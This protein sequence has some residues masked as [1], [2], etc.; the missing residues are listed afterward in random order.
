M[1]NTESGTRK[2]YTKDFK[3][4]AV[5]MLE[6]GQKTGEQIEE[7]LGIGSGQVYKWR[8]ELAAHGQQAFPGNGNPRDEELARLR[9][10]NANLREERDILRKAVAIFSKPSR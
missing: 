5:Q 4:R 6:A 7:D 8:K 2:R 9:K 1:E 10:E 3:L